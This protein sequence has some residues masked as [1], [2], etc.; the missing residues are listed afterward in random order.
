M[1]PQACWKQICDLLR[2][3]ETYQDGE[4][5]DDAYEQARE[6]IVERLNALAHWIEKGGFLPRP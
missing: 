1:D 4:M 5:D 6:D 2:E 3:C